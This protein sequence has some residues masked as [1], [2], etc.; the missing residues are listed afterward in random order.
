MQHVS[1][2]LNAIPGTGEGAKKYVRVLVRVFSFF[3][4]ATT[5]AKATLIKL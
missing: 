4:A 1:G 5:H 2:V 3:L